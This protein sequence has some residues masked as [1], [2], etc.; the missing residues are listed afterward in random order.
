MMIR[1]SL[2][3]LQNNPLSLS[4]Y[5]RP[6]ADWLPVFIAGYSVFCYICSVPC[7]YQGENVPRNLVPDRYALEKSGFLLLFFCLPKQQQ[8]TI[9]PRRA[10]C[11]ESNA[12]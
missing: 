8:T 11:Q 4:E 2:A 6:G 12:Q 7:D 1:L 9:S 3:Y 5:E 10:A